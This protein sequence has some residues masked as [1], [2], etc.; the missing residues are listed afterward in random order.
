MDAKIN[1]VTAGM[2]I[3]GNGANRVGV[4][5]AYRRGKYDLSGKGTS[6]RHWNRTSETKAGW[7]GGV[8]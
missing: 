1:G 4:F 5:G 6:L 7:A 3:Y 8:F 2:D